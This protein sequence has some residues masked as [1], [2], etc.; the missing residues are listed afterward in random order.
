MKRS[1][2]DRLLSIRDE[3]KKYI[4]SSETCRNY[5][6]SDAK[7]FTAY[8]T[9]T[10]LL[11]DTAESLDIHRASGFPQNPHQAYIEFWGVMQGIIIQQDSIGEL[12]DEIIGKRLN[13]PPKLKYPHNWKKLRVLRNICAGHPANKNRPKKDP[14]RRSFIGRGNISYHTLTYEVWTENQGKHI[15]ECIEHPEVPLGELIDAYVGEAAQIMAEILA[16]IKK[17]WPE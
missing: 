10:Y 7:L 2:M 5:F 8:Y 3:I 12:Y 1:E 6:Y 13:P 16:Y 17:T 9:S 11:Q 14:L 4:D 15:L